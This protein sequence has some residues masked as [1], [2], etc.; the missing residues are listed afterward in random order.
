ML[1]RVILA[2]VLLFVST[3]NVKADLIP[4]AGAGIGVDIFVPS[5][6]PITVKIFY[7][8]AEI[9]KAFDGVGLDLNWFGSGTAT[10]AGPSAGSLLTGDIPTAPPLDDLLIPPAPPLIGPGDSLTNPGLLSPVPFATSIGGGGHFDTTGTVGTGGG[11]YGLSPGP[12]S[13]PIDLMGADFIVTGSPGDMITFAPSGILPDDS[14]DPGDF[15]PISPGFHYFIAGGPTFTE[16][17]IGTVTVTIIPEPIICL[18]G[19]LVWCVSLRR[20]RS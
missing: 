17:I 3:V 1:R 19:L 5:G 6:T 20:R 12:F 4:D 8:P 18:P 14:I 2:T 9:P 15:T 10:P 11:A 16:T 13:V 7:S